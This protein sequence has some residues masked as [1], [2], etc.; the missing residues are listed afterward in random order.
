VT[1]REALQALATALPPGSAVSVPREWLL[2]L[3]AATADAPSPSTGAL[4]ATD[5]TVAD[6]ATRYG[7]SKAT[8]RAWCEAGR[9]PGAYRMH[10]SREW[11]IPQSG[12]E[13]FDTAERQRGNGKAGAQPAGR[14]R[15]RPINLGS[16]RSVS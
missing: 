3:L 2:A 9:F 14:S 16:W 8:A 4:P 11:R 10:G 5:L 13:S 1:D 6:L 15:T 12:V 7:R